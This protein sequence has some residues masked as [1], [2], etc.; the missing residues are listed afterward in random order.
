MHGQVGLPVYVLPEKLKVPV[1]RRDDTCITRCARDGD[2]AIMLR[3][4]FLW[5]G[6]STSHNTKL[7]RCP[8][9]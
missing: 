6:V 9:R 5:T 8:W 2:K 4:P 1:M 3:P 7:G